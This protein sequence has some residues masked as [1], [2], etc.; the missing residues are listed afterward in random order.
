MSRQRT[1]A[2]CVARSE[3]RGRIPKISIKL[4]PGVVLEGRTGGPDDVRDLINKGEIDG[5]TVAAA[6]IPGR[7]HSNP[8]VG[9]LF[10]DP[11]A[12]AK[13]YFKRTGIFPIMHLVGIRPDFG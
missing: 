7:G 1:F 4:P 11:I 13:D 5:Y 12:A 9:W 2:G 8:N 10:P 6:P 3:Q